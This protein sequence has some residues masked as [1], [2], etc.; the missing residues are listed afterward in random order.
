MEIVLKH[1]YNW[2]ENE[3][4]RCELN[5]TDNKRFSDIRMWWKRIN[6]WA[7]ASVQSWWLFR[8]VFWRRKKQTDR[9]TEVDCSN[10]N[11]LNVQENETDLQILMTCTN[12]QKRC[13][14]IHL[15][16][17]NSNRNNCRLF[18]FKYDSILHR[19]TKYKS[20]WNGKQLHTKSYR[21]HWILVKKNG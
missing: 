15:R 12:L 11:N 2:I 3:M 4:N 10:A 13:H 21:F 14:V 5:R 6:N 16:S 18:Q 8:F 9:Q 1:N 19:H 20:V 17:S 7:E